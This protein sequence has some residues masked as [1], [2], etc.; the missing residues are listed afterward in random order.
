MKLNRH[1]FLLSVLIITYNPGLLS[2]VPQRLNDL[3]VSTD[4][5]EEKMEDSLLVILHYGMKSE[6][7][8]EHIP[9]ARYISIWDLLVKDEQGIRHEFP[10]EQTMEQAFRS[11]GLNNNS[12]IIIC[13]QDG[14]GI[15]WAARLFLTLDYA[16]LGNQVAMLNG[17]LKAWREEGRPVTQGVTA[18]KEGTVDIQIRDEVR[19]S[20]EEVLAMLH[21]EDVVI[22][23]ARPGERYD[24]TIADNDS[25]RAGH[26]EGAVNMPIH[27][28]TLDDSTYMFKTE[29]DL[30][31]L[32]EDYKISS[33]SLIITYCG[34]GILASAD[35][36]A[37]RLLGYRVRFYDGLFQEWA[38]DES[39]PI[40]KTATGVR[41]VL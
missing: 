6:F 36:F 31:K 40:S 32:F 23:D 34:T 28:L 3:L 2:Q 12:K 41:F 22:V 25:T 33:E 8:K 15:R 26:I 11:W 29:N 19:I 30:R 16:G 20:K 39:L 35:Y 7:E 37:A 5:L 4:W 10:D 27:N 14:N 13:Y 18:F 1:L 17:G 38:S 9:G 24:G 21:R